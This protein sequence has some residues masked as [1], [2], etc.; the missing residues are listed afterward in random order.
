MTSGVIETIEPGQRYAQP[1]GLTWQV[2][3]LINF[4]GERK[5]HVQLINLRDPNTSK[6]VSVN[7]LLDPHLF[8]PVADTH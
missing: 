4:P 7:A 6:T 3:R 2:L 8:V 1:S 5:P